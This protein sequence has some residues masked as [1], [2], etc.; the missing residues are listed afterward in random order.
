MLKFHLWG[1][2]RAPSD[3]EMDANDLA[4]SVRMGWI[5]IRSGMKI[6]R[7]DIGNLYDEPRTGLWYYA[8]KDKAEQLLKNM[9]YGL[10]HDGHRFVTPNTW[11]NIEREKYAVIVEV[12][13][14]E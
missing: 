14:I 2:V 11:Y 12:N 7:V 13:V 6:Y 8:A 10:D 4:V 3:V 9:G 1:V 5:C